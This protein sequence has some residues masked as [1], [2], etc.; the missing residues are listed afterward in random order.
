[1]SNIEY[2]I[3]GKE[4]TMFLLN[5][6]TYIHI[7]IPYTYI[8]TYIYTYCTSNG[9]VCPCTKFRMGMGIWYAAWVWEYGIE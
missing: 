7:Y 6:D 3:T 9:K 2:M 5:S 1:M 4:T 8:H